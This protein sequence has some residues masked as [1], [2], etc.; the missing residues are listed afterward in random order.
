M[1]HEKMRAIVI[2]SAEREQS[3]WFSVVQA[4]WGFFT[5]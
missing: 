3:R 2:V 4:A 1:H 5:R